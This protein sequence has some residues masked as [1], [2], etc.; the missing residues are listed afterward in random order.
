ME[1]AFGHGLK[2]KGYI[3]D[4]DV[5]IEFRWVESQFHRLYG[6]VADLVRRQVTVIAAIGMPAALA[7][8]TATTT[9]PT[10]FQYLE[11][12]TRPW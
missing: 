9:I 7:A 1:A 3:V 5:A 6:L 8:K 12:W 10:V 2:E 4:R 11:G